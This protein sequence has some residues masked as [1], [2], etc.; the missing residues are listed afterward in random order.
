MKP[1]STYTLFWGS[2]P[3]F[4]CG[5]HALAS[6]IYFLAN[7]YVSLAI[8]SAIWI[9]LICEKSDLKYIYPKFI[10]AVIFIV[11]PIFILKMTFLLPDNKSEGQ[12]GQALIEISK[13]QF[14]DKKFGPTW[15]YSGVILEFYN[16]EEQLIAKNIPFHMFIAKQPLN[17]EG[18]QTCYLEG[19]LQTAATPFH[20]RFKPRVSSLLIHEKQSLFHLAN[21]RFDIQNAYK[22][23]LQ[24]LFAQSRSVEFLRGLITGTYDDPMLTL[25]LS[26]LGLQHIMA[27]SGLHFSILA[28]FLYLILQIWCSF[29]WKN[30]I[31]FLLLTFYFLF[32]GASPS[33]ERAWI[34]ISLYLIGN[35]LHKKA[36]PLNSLGVALLVQT[37][38]QPLSIFEIG[39]QFSFLAT[40]GILLGYEVVDTFLG[41]IT[42]KKALREII[43]ENIWQQ[44]VY[45]I[46]T[47]FRKNFA[48]ILAVHA[49]TI[50][51]TLYHFQQFSLLSLLYNLFFPSLVGLIMLMGITLSFLSLAIPISWSAIIFIPFERFISWSLDLAY[52]LP[53]NLKIQFTHTFTQPYTVTA[54]LALTC[55]LWIYL[56]QRFADDSDFNVLL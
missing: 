35:V 43:K 23:L 29:R 28:N 46:A 39:F 32:V 36:T 2:H 11:I 26:S 27:V 45:I 25:E 1:K 42:N 5:L 30:L 10:K 22:Q 52:N 34:T 31:A 13:I 6:L 9:P 19:I 56:K 50:P 24:K 37:C 12:S 55:L 14:S 53:A 17:L 48:L 20:Y 4:F 38:F 44:H 7:P 49:L 16:R 54:F 33:I 3:A 41:K 15:F 51:L 21:W 18:N 8:F 47:F 40:A